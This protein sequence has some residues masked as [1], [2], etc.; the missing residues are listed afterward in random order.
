MKL[1][2]S[3]VDFPLWRKKVD[4]S[5]LRH[6]GTTIP[7]WVCGLWDINGTFSE[8]NS[9]KQDESAV[10]IEFENKH[11]N[12]SVTVAKHGREKSPAYRLWFSDELAYELKNVFI[13]S[14]VRDIEARLREAKG[15]KD[16]EIED[17]IPFWEFL[18]IEYDQENRK[19][20]FKAYYTQ[21]PT[22]FEL[23]STFVD[24]SPILH[25]I[26]DE[27]EEKPPFRIYKTTWKERSKL[28]TELGPKNVLYYLTDTKNKLLYIG[29]A[30]SLVARLNQN[31]PSIP[32]W[33]FYRY[34][35]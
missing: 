23:F 33:D 5:L 26:D 25:K 13:M 11:F 14:Y 6:K 30:S 4:S 18:D 7:Q 1:E 8:C 16:K 35:I 27:L 20:F 31:H 34:D 15:T 12:G 10:E 28:D 21:K 9:K 22:F 17:D 19:F 32:E 29:E 24:E 3:D 2:R